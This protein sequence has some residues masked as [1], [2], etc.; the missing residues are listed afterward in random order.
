MFGK[1][2]ILYAADLL[3]NNDHILKKL[4]QSCISSA[5]EPAGNYLLKV[6]NRNTRTRCDVCSKLTL[7]IPERRQWR[8][9]GIF[10]VNFDMFY[11]LF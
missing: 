8:R 6:N 1:L 3:A 11:E 10:S 5:C 9:S 2:G 4:R 7:K